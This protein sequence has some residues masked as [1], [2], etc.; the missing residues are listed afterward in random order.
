[1]K[2]YQAFR[3]LNEKFILGEGPVYDKDKDTLTWVDIKTGSLHGLEPDGNR[4]C[5]QTGQYLGAAIPVKGKECYL[6]VMTGGLYLIKRD[7]IKKEYSLSAEIQ[8]YQRANDAK[9]DPA[10]RLWFGTMPLFSKDL[11]KGGSIYTYAL[12]EK[13]QKKISHTIVANGMAWRER[14]FYFIDSGTRKVYACDYE[15][16]TGAIRNQREILSFD[17]GTPDGMTIDQEGMLWIARWGQGAVGRYNPESG[18]LIAEI[19]VPATHVSSC[20]FGG[21]NRDVL[22]ITSSQEGLMGEQDGCL[23]SCR[24]DVPGYDTDLFDGDG[25]SA[26]EIASAITWEE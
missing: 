12:A 13:C 18:E 21:E 1:M 15:Q 14:I 9:C 22:Y 19:N 17:D 8:D 10:G 3:I 20:C 16:S 7:G 2:E 25:R 4:F 11:K 5:V 23:F 26:A 24:V 6:G